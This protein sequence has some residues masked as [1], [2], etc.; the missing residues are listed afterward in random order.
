MSPVSGR[1]ESNP[2]PKLGELRFGG[3]LNPLVTAFL[4][5]R[6]LAAANPRGSGFATARQS[7]FA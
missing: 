1:W 7:V 5:V 2:R 6:S 4:R 3:H